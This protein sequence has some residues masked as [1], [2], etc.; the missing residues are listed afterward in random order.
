MGGTELANGVTGD[1]VIV[2]GTESDFVFGGASRYDFVFDGR[3]SATNWASVADWLGSGR[4][5]IWRCCPSVSKVKWVD[6]AGGLV[7]PS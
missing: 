3:G 1:D 5:S 7:W 6:G 4:L 2:R